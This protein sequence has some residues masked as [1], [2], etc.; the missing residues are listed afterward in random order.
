[1]KRVSSIPSLIK[2]EVGLNYSMEPWRCICST[3][4]NRRFFASADAVR[5]RPTTNRRG[6]E[7]DHREL[8]DFTSVYSK[9]RKDSELRT[10]QSFQRT[11]GKRRE[12]I[13][14]VYGEWDEPFV[15]VNKPSGLQLKSKSQNDY[16]IRDSVER[17]VREVV[18]PSADIEFPQPLGE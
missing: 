16:E 12:E 11:E 13:E 5:R 1:M 17:R 3:T 18:G 4:F 14:L 8:E 2:G 9:R 6:G 15:I 7:G 10:P